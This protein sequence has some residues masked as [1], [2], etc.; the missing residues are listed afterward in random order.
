MPGQGGTIGMKFKTLEFTLTMN[1]GT[2]SVTFGESENV[3]LDSTSSQVKWYDAARARV[4]YAH[5]EYSRNPIAPINAAIP[6]VGGG[7][8]ARGENTYKATSAHMDT[9]KGEKHY[10]IKTLAHQKF[11]LVLYPERPGADKI[12]E[13]M[14]N[15]FELKLEN[16]SVVVITDA[17]GSKVG[18]VIFN[19]A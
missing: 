11:G 7:V 5:K 13:M 15:E 9:K 1:Y 12:I 16:V 8:G 10:T 2:H 14:G 6:P 19:G 4:E 18:E 3:E 17:K